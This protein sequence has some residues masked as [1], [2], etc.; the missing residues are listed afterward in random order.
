MSLGST[1]PLREM[2]TRNIPGCK[3]RPALKADNLTTVS[4]LSRKWSLDVSQPYG[5][6][7]PVTGIALLYFL[8]NVGLRVP[9]FQEIRF[10]G[11]KLSRME[12]R[13]LRAENL[14]GWNGKLFHLYP[15]TT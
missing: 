10:L 7:W 2:S 14:N 8:L 1:Q 6:P 5:P 13:I 11:N 15:S 12:N 4:R 3:G 9:I